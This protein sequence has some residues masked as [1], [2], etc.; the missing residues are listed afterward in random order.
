MET[1]KL[2]LDTSSALGF[3]KIKVGSAVLVVTTNTKT[4]KVK[5]KYIGV[6][7]DLV[8][9]CGNSVFL[10]CLDNEDRAKGLFADV[11]FGKSE[12]K[13]GKTISFNDDE[14]QHILPLTFDFINSNEFKD[15]YIDII[16]MNT[17]INRF[18]PILSKNV[19]WEK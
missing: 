13:F 16:Q 4:K 9:K 7:T 5:V 10:L 15:C 6:V 11:Y 14:I 17:M 18:M 19:I 2:D 1:I 3:N 12:F 8:T